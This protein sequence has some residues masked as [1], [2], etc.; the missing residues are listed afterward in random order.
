MQKYNITKE[1]KYQ[2]FT[3]DERKILERLLN[4]K[5]S[6]QEIRE[7]LNKSRSTIWRELKRKE[8][9]E[10]ILKWN[11]PYKKYIAEIAQENYED[12]RTACGRK[13]GFFQCQKFIE[14]VE[15][16]VLNKHYSPEQAIGRIKYLQI[17]MGN[18]VT[19]RT[20]YNYIE[21][22][23]IKIKRKH[24]RFKERRKRK[25]KIIRKNKRILG[26]SIELRPEIVNERIEF[27]HFETDLIVDRLKNC[28]LVIQERKT[29]NF[30][31]IKCQNSKAD[32]I[33]FKINEKLSELGSIIK[34]ITTDNGSEFSKLSNLENENLKIYFTHPY[35]AYEKGGIENLNSLI[36]RFIP[37]GTNLKNI[38]QELLDKIQD[39]INNL[40]RKIL[41][42][43]TSNEVWQE[44]ITQ[45]A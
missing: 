39:F 26:K 2:H 10:N 42:F 15:D 32:E 33:N 3:N 25:H 21:L 41:G 16:L 1:N 27:G 9:Y 43:K 20:I 5:K 22:S 44:Q 7:I 40:P 37:K 23:L 8:N 31:L 12:R 35:S 45:I 30:Y 28:V 17:S 29:R 36:R 18:V 24:L 38:T 11:K 34:T 13:Y 19:L 6:L 4:Q 14:T